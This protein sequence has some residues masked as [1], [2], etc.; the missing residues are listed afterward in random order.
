MI[1]KKKNK[2]NTEIT[3]EDINH[4]SKRMLQKNLQ[5]NNSLMEQQQKKDK[6][7]LKE[8]IKRNKQAKKIIKKSL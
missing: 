8:K 3:K 5:L 4:L 7:N 6:A 2:I 1:F